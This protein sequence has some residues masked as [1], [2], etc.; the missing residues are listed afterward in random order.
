LFLVSSNLIAQETENQ[1]IL[2]DINEKYNAYEATKLLNLMLDVSESDS[3]R[4][5]R[6]DKDQMGMRHEKFTQYYQDIKVEYTAIKIH[7]KEEIANLLT[8]EYIKDISLSIQPKL[9]METAFNLAKEYIN[10]EKYIWDDDKMYSMYNELGYLNENELVIVKDYF[11]QEEENYHLAYK[12]DIYA[13]E[14]LSRDYIYVSATTGQILHSNPLIKSCTIKGKTSLTK[15]TEN[16]KSVDNL[17]LGSAVTRYSGTRNIETSLDNQNYYVLRD[18]TRGTGVSTY[19]LNN[20]VSYASAINFQD[21]DNNWSNTEW[22]NAQKDNAALDAHWGAAQTYDFFMSSFGRNSFDNNG[23]EIKSY[24]HYSS[25]FFN[26]FWNGSV[27]TYG[28][29]NANNGNEP[30]TT[31]DICAH[32]VGHAVCTHTADL[33]YSYESGALNESFSDIW[34]A[35]VEFFSDPTKDTWIIG[36]EM[37]YPIRSMSN[38]NTYN[39]PDTYQGTHWY[40]GSGDNGGVHTNSGVLNYWFYLLSE[41]GSGTNDIG[42]VY[43]VSGIGIQK[44]A[45][46]AYR[47]E[48]VYLSTNSQYSD[49]YTF[50]LQAAEDLYGFNSSE[51]ISVNNAWCAV[52]LGQCI[53]CNQNEV[54]T[55]DVTPNSFDFKQADLTITASNTAFSGSEAI[56]HAG[57]EVLLVSGFDA[58]NGS[59]FRGYIE[60]CTGTYTSKS[61]SDVVVEAEVVKELEI[62]EETSVDGISIFPNPTNGIFNLRCTT[63]TNSEVLLNIINIT[64]KIVY[65]KEFSNV[66]NNQ[67]IPIDINNLSTGV[68]FVKVNIDGS[69]FTDKII[70][71]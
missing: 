71:N 31:V 5:E 66:S 16:K 40:A 23:A 42:T 64:G 12:F 48:S 59:V 57:E 38:P 36:E 21:N 45:Q 43:N 14:P 32:E 54:I 8:G 68:Y 63:N 2:L 24:V 33:V 41:G 52:G 34:G 4:L 55:M 7:Y 35:C 50:S 1:K 26:A 11:N 60:G 47:T 28:D 70:K 29:G 44:A 69:S 51:W 56:Y 61:D 17:I 25:N 19:D 6:E 65:T 3:F 49:A 30:L 46:I 18:L 67:T 53:G 20:S 37:G 9:S 27:M 13:L 58:L 39:H 10:A 22:N 15:S 62:A